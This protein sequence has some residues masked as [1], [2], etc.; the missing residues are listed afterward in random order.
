MLAD[1]LREIDG[2]RLVD[3]DGKETVVKL[4][5]PA[6]DEQL[7]RLQAGLPCP[8]PDE[9]RDALRVTTG[10]ADGPLESFSL[11]DLEGFGLEEAFPH[12]YSLAHDGYGNYWVLDLLPGSTDW[13]PVFY[14]CHDPPVIAYQAPSIEAFLRDVVAMPVDDPRSPIDEVHERVV[15]RIW[16]ENPGLRSQGEALASPDSAV[17]EFAATLPG[18]AMIADMRSA[19]RGDGFSWG[20]H[21]PRTELRRCGTERIWAIHRPARKPGLLSRLFGR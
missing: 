17:R 14:A 7:R 9:I 21:G 18:D 11:L 19:R 15:N 13:G 20:R 8:L 4:Q 10:L 2:R 12:A 1:A 5:P 6:T 3:A 16:S